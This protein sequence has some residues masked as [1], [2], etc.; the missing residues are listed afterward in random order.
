M[1]HRYSPLKIWGAIIALII[2][3]HANAQQMPAGFNYQAVARNSSGLALANQSFNVRV[4]V[5]S[6][7]VTVEYSEIHANIKTNKLGLFNIVIGKG[8]HEG[9]LASNILDVPWEKGNMFIRTEVDFGNGFVAMGT[10]QLFSVPYAFFAGQIKN[11]EK[12]DLVGPTGATGPTGPQGPAGPQ[13]VQGPKGPTGAKGATGATGARGATGPQGPVG[14]QGNEGPTGPQGD[15]GPQGEQGWPGDE[16]PQG[17]IG[18]AGPQG[19]IGPQGIQGP[20]GPQGDVGPIGPQG[21]AGAGEQG[22]TGP[23]GIQGLVGPTGAT[24]AGIQGPTGPQGI[25]G[26][27]GPQGPAGANGA[28]GA[29]GLQGPTGPAGSSNAWGLSGNA[30]T[31]PGSNFIG[32]IDF[33]DVVFGSGNTEVARLIQTK[34]SV[35]IGTTVHGNA[36]LHVVTAN[37][38]NA[39]LFESNVLSDNNDIVSSKFNG[40]VNQKDVSAYYGRAVMSDWYGYGAYLEAGY[41]GT[42]CELMPTGNQTYYGFRTY[43]EGG[44]G[45]NHGIRSQ[46]YNGRKDYGIRTQIYDCDT[47]YTVFN[48]ITASKVNSFNYGSYTTIAANSTNARSYGSA[49]IITASS[50]QNTNVSYMGTITGGN[51]T[52]Y[53]TGLDL[54]INATG[55][56]TNIGGNININGGTN[57]TN[58][59]YSANLAGGG[60]TNIGLNITAGAVVGS[61][62]I[63]TNAAGV[64]TTYSGPYSVNAR[65]MQ[66]S[67]T[68]SINSYSFGATE[69]YGMR[70]AESNN[71]AA[72][73]FGLVGASSSSAS[74]TSIGV[75]GESSGGSSASYGVVG[76][77]SGASGNGAGVY[78]MGSNGNK[79]ARFDGNVDAN[80]NVTISGD[81]MVAGNKN[82]K[83]DHP[84][85]PENK[86]LVHYCI[87]GAEAQNI[88]NGN[89]TTDASGTA[90]VDLPAYF[91]AAN[92]NVKYQL[93]VIGDFAQAIIGQEVKGNRFIIKTNKPNIKVSWQ[94]TATRNDKYAQQ[95]GYQAEQMKPANERGTYLMP[96]L[97]GKNAKAPTV[98][99]NN[100]K[101]NYSENNRTLNAATN[102]NKLGVV[103]PIA[104]DKDMK[105]ID[106]KKKAL[107]S[108]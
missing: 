84:L 100:N 107:S 56:G 30:G 80:G 58:Y 92:T 36:K 73:S 70:G 76:M 46:I 10:M 13:G 9:G 48:Q 34:K 2:V 24:G 4:S 50:A 89:I 102:E 64:F 54:T 11:Q 53:N 66:S 108:K 17:P 14:A 55:T 33:Q 83:I 20:I 1:K 5:L 67:G 43:L 26:G 18:P 49:N 74:A 75:Y 45:M 101:E 98:E 90:V 69:V 29:T 77:A 82:F 63:K 81:L 37:T 57:S 71:S 16:G 47:S 103:Y 78:G 97:Y 88:Y 42:Y 59:G 94:V 61:P 86:Y 85:D 32:S 106:N 72:A 15:V 40:A 96:E 27:I 22:P 51:N 19:E 41:I 38:D 8:K 93:T 91:E 68:S 12:A 87:E 23:Q 99:P 65:V 28:T 95:H 52:L 35:G 44:T 104:E 39:G 62:A 7:S 31:T 3:L 105:K 21:P 6:D 60:T 79:A 25:A